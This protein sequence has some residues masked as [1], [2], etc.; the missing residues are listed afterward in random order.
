MRTRLVTNL[1]LGSKPEPPHYLPVIYSWNGKQTGQATPLVERAIL[2][3]F[4]PVDE[5]VVL[6]TQQV[7]ERWFDTGLLAREVGRQVVERPLDSVIVRGRRELGGGFVFSVIDIQT[8]EGQRALFRQTVAD[9]GAYEDNPPER[10]LFDVTHGFRTQPLLG[11]AA[12][13]FTL[14]EWSRRRLDNP[15]VLQILYGAFDAKQDGVSPIWD[16]TEFV[17]ASRWNSALDALLRYGRADDLEALASAESRRALEVARGRGERGL[18]LAAHGFV[19]RL[20]TAARKYADDLSL[21]RLLY[22]FTESAPRLRELLASDDASSWVK[23]LPVLESAVETLKAQVEPLCSPDVTGRAGLRATHAFAELS[24]RLQ[25][26]AEQAAA[27]REAAVTRYALA[28]GLP[29]VEPK[30]KGAKAARERQ[31]RLLGALARRVHDD[32]QFAGTLPEREAEFARLFTSIGDRRNDI[33]HLGL[34]ENTGKAKS[35]REGLARYC[36]ELAPFALDPGEAP[37]S[38]PAA[39][40][41]RFLNLSNHPLSEWPQAQLDAARALDLGEPCELGGGMPQVDPAADT[42]EVCKL[43]QAIAKRALEAGAAGACVVGEYTLTLALVAALQREGVRCFA[44]TTARVAKTRT[45][46]DG[47][48]ETTRGFE[49]QAWREYPGSRDE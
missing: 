41:K 37:P 10:V 48:V 38:P 1:G 2:E 17:E 31:E 26:F 39:A 21:G 22:L 36:G 40:E 47:S 30:Q 46:P 28:N 6:G 34:N 44:S 23:R 27:L 5:V 42:A 13:A 49:F 45:L 7:K 20:G 35:L 3:L 8:L 43:A 29:R 25:R 32:R 18:E 19:G 15:P 9:L 33:E 12:V 24:G 11:M 4:E 14:S 16:V